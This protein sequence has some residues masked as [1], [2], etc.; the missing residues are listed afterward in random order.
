[1]QSSAVEFCFSFEWLAISQ[2]LTLPVHFPARKQHEC[3]AAMKRTNHKRKRFCLKIEKKIS[4]KSAR[5]RCSMERNLLQRYI[6]KVDVEHDAL[7]CD[8]IF[9]SYELGDDVENWKIE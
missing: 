9:I 8:E 7:L 3:S 5:S 4:R 2:S 1:M 6:I